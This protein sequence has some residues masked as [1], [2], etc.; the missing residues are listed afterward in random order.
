MKWT[1]FILVM[2]LAGGLAG[3]SQ[4]VERAKMK[5]PALVPWPTKVTIRPGHYTVPQKT[6]IEWTSPE[7]RE[8]GL[9]VANTLAGDL[10]QLGFKPTVRRITARPYGVSFEL[11]IR[12]DEALGPE[13][14]RLHVTDGIQV[15]ANTER[16]LFLGTRTA[17]Q[18]VEGGPGST[19]SF[20][21]IVDAPE[22][23]YR[24]A[25]VDVARQFHSIEF[26]REMVKKLARYKLN[27]YHIH[28]T[29]DQSWTLPSEKF[30]GLPTKG[31]HY[32]R[33][34]LEGLVEFAAKYHVTIVPE[35]DMPG[36]SS[37][38]CAAVPDVVCEG[39][40][41]SNVVCAG[42]ER[43]YAALE[44][45]IG[46][47]MAI[48]P[49]PYFHIGAD[50]VNV[51][52]WSGCPDCEATIRKHDLEDGHALY[53]YFINRIHEFV[54]SEGRTM[55]VWEGFRP[56]RRPAVDK[57]VIVEQWWNGYVQPEAT[58][59]A[60]HAIINAS[61]APLYLVH[62]A[63]NPPEILAEW[64]P[65]CFGRGVTMQRAE[66]M[67]RFDP[68]PQ[69]IGT[70]M[71]SWENSEASEMG[72]FFGEGEQLDGYAV[73]APRLQIV[74][75]RAWTGGK[76]KVEDLLSRIRRL[77]KVDWP[78]LAHAEDGTMLM[79]VR[80]AVEVT[81]GKIISSL[82]TYRENA[83]GRAFDGK[84]ET[85]FWSA[86]SAQ[87]GDTF[88]YFLDEAAAVE[89]IKIVTGHEEHAEDYVHEGILE[90]SKDADTF[91]EAATF[92]EGAVDVRLGGK[93][94]K[95]IR[96]RMTKSQVYWLIIRE[97]AVE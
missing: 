66:D 13:G 58:M 39:K 44:A 68:T 15:Q 5:N 77:D 61:W 33:K 96:I 19:V 6:V 28:F 81:G 34:Q 49:G 1:A 54:K 24:A 52:V 74:A 65:L 35:I 10:Q 26:H 84:D 31:R 22:Y 50:E 71:C 72:L 57:D 93:T 75:E 69:I 64:N 46:E 88:T 18:L 42:S 70:C 8:A 12:P 80:K 51:G 36:H 29:D 40:K 16:G 11:A 53:N 14:Y 62:S 32:T 94:I 37:A 56:E 25:M 30:P 82:P 43:S 83:P 9:R 86:R 97:I 23:T 38:I 85:F 47:A 20:L 73:P 90:V 2:A 41:R 60:G 17:L 21:Q 59:K 27:V 48:F 55:I 7:Q 78:G 63:V 76:T 87:K 89:S 3:V 92:E 67:F 79:P 91:E 4:G 95:A 45:L